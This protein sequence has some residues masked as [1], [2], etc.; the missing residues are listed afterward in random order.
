MLAGLAPEPFDGDDW[1]FELKWDGYRCLLYKNR[2]DLYLDSRNGKPLL[3]QFPSLHS[4][5]DVLRCR[6]ALVDGEIVA[7]KD[8]RVDFSLLR[9]GESSVSYVAFDL[10][11]VDGEPLTEL[12]L[13]ARRA[14]LKGRMTH[15][16]GHGGVALLSEAVESEGHALFRWAKEQDME[17]IMAK[18]RDSLYLPGQR[19][20]D[21]L[22]IKNKQEGTFWVVGY[23]PSPGRP[24]ASLVVAQKVPQGYRLV[25][26]VSTGLNHET[27]N[28]LLSALHPLAE[29]DPLREAFV[30]ASPLPTRADTKRVNWVEP[31]FG[32]EV[33]YTEMTPDGH[34][35]HPVLREVEVSHAK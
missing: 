12:P 3:P 26:R 30:R 8:G 9:R 24:L 4:A 28:R 31:Y 6:E 14:E 10:L 34:L 32:V 1:I 11:W 35:R 21:W 27:E 22:K 19:T 5:G 16:G 33:E 7:I 20:K 13:R 18:R 17:G 23:L 25:G 15:G 29:W 2:D